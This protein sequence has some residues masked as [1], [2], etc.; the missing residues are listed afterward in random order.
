MRLLKYIPY[1]ITVAVIGCMVFAACKKDDAKPDYNADKTRLKALIDSVTLIYNS[2]I[3]GNKPGNYA[4]G[5]KVPLKSSIDLALQVNTGN[6]YAQDDV[7]NT[8]ANLRRSAQDFSNRQIQEVSVANLVAQ[9][10]FDGNAN[11]A[12]GHGH[13][14][15]LRTGWIGKDSATAVDGATLPVLVADRFNRPNTAYSFNKG[16]HIEVPYEAS[17]NP[18]NITISLWLKRD[19]TSANNYILSL[20]RW[21]GFKFQLQSNN[22]LFLTFKDN[23]GIYHDVDD[24]PGVIP[25]GVW[26]HAAVTY[27]SGALKFYINGALVRTVTETG[28]P[29]TLPKPVNMAIGNELPKSVYSLSAGDF[30]FYGG[31]YFMGSM[32]EIR[33]YSTALSDAEV[34][35]IYTIEKSL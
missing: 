30:A 22:F 5:S 7:D 25:Q 1:T 19:T 13:T 11:D 28:V 21:N 24:N 20:N 34:L 6:T 23:T 9:W 16:A 4:I 17:L 8:I 15:M 32:D 12:S 2:A 10:K 3:E 29:V 18:Q 31:N 33:F 14:G 27:T 35:S 26:T